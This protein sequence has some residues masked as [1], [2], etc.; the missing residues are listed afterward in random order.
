MEDLPLPYLRITFKESHSV[1]VSDVKNHFSK[2]G[3][4]ETCKAQ[5]DTSFALTY[6]SGQ[7]G[8]NAYNSS[9]AAMTEKKGHVF[10]EHEAMLSLMKKGNFSLQCLEDENTYANDSITY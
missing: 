8:K 5:D 9:Q 10:G 4:I 7:D 1:S 3:Q 6:A 2:Y